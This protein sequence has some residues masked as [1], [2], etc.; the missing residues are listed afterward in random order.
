[1]EHRAPVGPFRRSPPRISQFCTSGTR[2][3]GIQH[4]RQPS[5]GPE[6][7]PFVARRADLRSTQ[8]R[9]AVR[10]S[11]NR[12]LLHA[13]AKRHLVAPPN[14]R[15]DLENRQRSITRQLLAHGEWRLLAQSRM[16]VSGTVFW[17]LSCGRLA[18]L[19]RGCGAPCVGDLVDGVVSDGGTSGTPPGP[20]FVGRDSVSD[21]VVPAATAL[22]PV[23]RGVVD[24][25]HRPT[26]VLVLT[27]LVLDVGQP[28]RRG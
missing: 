1:M 10:G 25:S 15:R 27:A 8:R 18:A 13:G 12:R 24:H 17:T 22:H 21:G 19:F 7:I 16:A 4:S 2:T 20:R 23:S 28:S 11:W 3:F 5:N 26:T 9:A 6:P 14:R